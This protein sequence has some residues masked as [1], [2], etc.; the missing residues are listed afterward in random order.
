MAKKNRK[1]KKFWYALAT[2]VSVAALMV[3]MSADAP[4]REHIRQVQEAVDSIDTV[5]YVLNPITTISFMNDTLD[6]Y[7]TAMLTY[8][9]SKIVRNLVKN[10][11]NHRMQLPHFSH[12]LRH[13]HNKKIKY[14]IKI[15]YSPSQFAQLR[16]HEEISANVAAILTA[17][18]EYQLAQDKASVMK[19]YEKTYMGYYFTAI[20]NGTI[21]PESKNPEDL[22]KKYT[23]LVNGAITMWEK[24]FRTHY[25]PSLRL[26][27][28]QYLKDYGFRKPY[29]DNYQRILSHMY[30]FGGKDLSHY[31][32]KDASYGDIRANIFDEMAYV[33]I[34]NNS[35]EQR[36]ILVDGITDYAGYLS[37]FS[38]SQ[39]PAIIEHIVIASRLKFEL[40]KLKDCDLASNSPAITAA[41]HKV[42]YELARDHQYASFV[43]R[44][45]ELDFIA[46]PHKSQS[47]EFGSSFPVSRLLTDDNKAIISKIYQFRDVDL[48]KLIKDF[49][50]NFMP[51]DRNQLLQ[52][53]IYHFIDKPIDYLINKAPI[54]YK[55]SALDDSAIVSVQ[56]TPKRISDAVNT[57][58][59]HT[60]Q[61]LFVNIPDFEE[62]IL[63]PQAMTPAA[64]QKLAEMFHDFDA[65]PNEFKN[66]NLN[67]T[68]KF[69]KQHVNPRYFENI[70]QPFLPDSN[71][72][73]K[74]RKKCTNPRGKDAVTIRRL[75]NRR[76]SE[77]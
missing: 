62:N 53:N 67:E 36:A 40:K 32:V 28:K 16:M 20:K 15:R 73:L 1:S 70:S 26:S 12:E 49:D 56:A 48:T 4:R 44:C 76:S 71:Y 52:V 31:I 17:D 9:N 38:V 43:N 55:A 60:S 75:N 8:Q 45:K 66:C 25:S 61:T 5:D 34:F 2:S 13:H 11:K 7:T 58:P 6:Y 18:F 22:D 64:Y 24:T 23:L 39:R 42:M 37:N 69:I 63:Q 77:H 74:R 30:A 57:Y 14:W 29:P 21:K 3:G 47:L 41:Y 59:H 10:S 46:A 33:K 27:L 35:L 72:P 50:I 19:K 51:S 68:Q 65:I 54:N